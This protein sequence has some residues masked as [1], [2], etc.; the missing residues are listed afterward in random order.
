MRLI[1]RLVD[2]RVEATAAE[3]APLQS[4]VHGV[5]INA[6]TMM[7]EAAVVRLMR[8]TMMRTVGRWINRG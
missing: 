3:A 1:V 5:A 6:A 8:T 4:R 7:V 2:L